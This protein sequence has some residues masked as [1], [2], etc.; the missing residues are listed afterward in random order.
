MENT[1]ALAGIDNTTVAAIAG[2]IGACCL[3]A[4]LVIM[5]CTCR[6]NKSKQNQDQR[7]FSIAIE[8]TPIEFESAR[9]FESA[10]PFESPRLDYGVL[11][12]GEPANSRPPVV[13]VY[14]NASDISNGGG[15]VKSDYSARGLTLPPTPGGLVLPPPP[16]RSIGGSDQDSY[17][18]LSLPH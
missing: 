8:R 1:S 11:P 9:Q 13:N 7:E 3:V 12:T 18:T 2:G 15:S 4:I 10:R 14:M 16:P 6:A 17:S 5:V